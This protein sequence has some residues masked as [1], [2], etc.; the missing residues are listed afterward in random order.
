MRKEPI[1]VR[2]EPAR[3][4]LLILPRRAGD[5]TLGTE[6]FEQRKE[7]LY[8]ASPA[9]I[10]REYCKHF[11]NRDDFW[12]DMDKFWREDEQFAQQNNR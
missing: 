11:A 9:E 8:T 1:L 10:A 3:V 2:I 6:S 12:M 4:E 5:Y 7:R